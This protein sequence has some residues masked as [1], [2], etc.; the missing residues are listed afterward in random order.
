M[1][2]YP[3][4]EMVTTAKPH[5]K[6]MMCFLNI[7]KMSLKSPTKQIMLIRLMI[8]LDMYAKGV[9]NNTKQ[10]IIMLHF[11]ETPIFTRIIGELLDD[12][13]Y[14]SLQLELLKNP[15]KGDLVVGGGGIRKIRCAAS[16]KGKS[17]GVRVIYYFVDEQGVFYMLY[18]YP[19]SKMDNLS[20]EK[21]SLL[22]NLVKQELSDER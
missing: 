5:R 4:E 17:G 8:K 20:R 15:H 1:A 19:K 21:L 22:R 18:A 3:K 10:A 9:Y 7:G 16:N 11:T 13:N 12:E 14:Y 2:R 6:K